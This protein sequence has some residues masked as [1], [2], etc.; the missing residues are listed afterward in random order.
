MIILISILN[1]LLLVS[2]QEMEA[3]VIVIDCREEEERGDKMEVHNMCSFSLCCV[4]F[5][6][7]KYNKTYHK[8]HRYVAYINTKANRMVIRSCDIRL[9]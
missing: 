3:I 4:T 1:S 8:I 6:M 5:W 9:W 2:A 7:Q